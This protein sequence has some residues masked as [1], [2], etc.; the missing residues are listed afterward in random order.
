MSRIAMLGMVN[1]IG[2]M[3]KEVE[4]STIIELVT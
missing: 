3:P 2:P 1:Y 4:E